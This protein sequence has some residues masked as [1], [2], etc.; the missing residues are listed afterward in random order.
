MLLFDPQVKLLPFSMA[1]ICLLKLALDNVNVDYK[2][3]E[4]TF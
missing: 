2:G 3:L 4:S 1:A